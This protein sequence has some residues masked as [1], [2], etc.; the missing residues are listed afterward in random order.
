MVFNPNLD[1]D[2]V[3][4]GAMTHT[5]AEGNSF[6]ECQEGG[7]GDDDDDSAG[8]AVTPAWYVAAAGVAAYWALGL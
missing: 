4:V 7:D 1:G 3:F 8:M 6:V 5:G 2:C